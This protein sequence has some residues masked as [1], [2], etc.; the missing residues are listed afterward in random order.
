MTVTGSKEWLEYVNV[1]IPY[2]LHAIEWGLHLMRSTSNWIE[3][4]SITIVIDGKECVK[5]DHRTLVN[6]AIELAIIYSRSL[7][8]FLGLKMRYRDRR[9]I[10]DFKRRIDDVCVENFS[11]NGR[12]LTRITCE[13]AFGTYPGN[14]EDARTALLLVAEYAD[15]AVAHLTSGPQDNDNTRELLILALDGVLALMHKFFYDRIE[16][17]RPTSRIRVI[18]STTTR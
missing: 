8:E 7:L 2:R 4:K 15:K 1:N 12:S 10:C 5:T 13:D 14:Y 6:P 9:L 3:P 16:V 11:F 17:Q 18:R